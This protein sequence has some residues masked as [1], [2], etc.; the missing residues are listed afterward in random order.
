MTVNSIPISQPQILNV[1]Q[2]D[3]SPL[4]SDCQIKIMQLG[5]NRNGSVM[6]RPTVDKM[7]KTLRGCPIVGYYKKDKDDFR[8]HGE[9]LTVDAD[10]LNFNYLTVPYGFIAPDA[11]IWYQDFDEYDEGSDVPIRRTYLMTTGFLWTGQQPECEKVIREGRP[12]SMELDE[13]FL[14]GYWS[15]SIND[16]FDLFIITDAIFSK[17]CILGQDVEPCFEGANITAS[18]SYKQIFDK[19]LFT[20]MQEFKKIKQGGNADMDENKTPVVEAAAQPE[21]TSPAEPTTFTAEPATEPAPAAEP[22]TIQLTETGNW[23]KDFTELKQKYEALEKQNGEL[24][25]FQKTIMKEKKQA[26]IE[27]FSML[28]EEDLKPVMD[29]LDTFALDTLEDELYKILGK[30]EFKK[31]ENIHIT[32]DNKPEPEEAPPATTFTINDTPNAV[33]DWVSALETVKAKSS[34]F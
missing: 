30:V 22:E 29:K 11:E 1:Q 19:S 16:S 32:Q 7:A 3:I 24:I 9:V 6:D 10:G 14:E 5:E 27:K 23:V 12:Q 25:E 26:L 21:E 8:D 17:L 34:E 4:I 15:N 13:H 33:P 18:F 2:N 28:S 31:Y 20:F